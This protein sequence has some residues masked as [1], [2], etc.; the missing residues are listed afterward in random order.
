ME[1]GSKPDGEQSERKGS[2]N[3]QVEKS[4]TNGV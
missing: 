4:G 3:E 2:S 1:G